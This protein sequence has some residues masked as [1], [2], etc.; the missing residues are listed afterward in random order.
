MPCPHQATALHRDSAGGP[1]GSAVLPC[2]LGRKERVQG[3]TSP[4]SPLG[5]TSCPLGSDPT[6][7]GHSLHKSISTA[8]SPL[9]RASIC[10]RGTE[11]VV[12]SS[13]RP[14]SP[15]TPEGKIKHNSHRKPPPSSVD[16]ELN[17]CAQQLIQT[18]LPASGH[19]APLP[20]VSQLQLSLGCRFHTHY[21]NL[22][23]VLGTS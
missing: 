3:E 5:V 16:Q 1:L 12:T 9:Q 15:D 8:P 19:P 21:L 4:L 10:D 6:V 2:S 17:F 11:R 7:L 23:T 20:A 14:P 18:G 13:V 22:S